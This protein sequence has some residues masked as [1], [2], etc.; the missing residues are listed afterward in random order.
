MSQ[1]TF[2]AMPEIVWALVTAAVYAASQVVLTADPSVIFT[3]TFWQT[4][5]AVAAIR[6]VAGAFL[7]VK[8]YPGPGPQPP[9][10]PPRQSYSTLIMPVQNQEPVKQGR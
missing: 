6:A 8:T 5:V 10:V 9:Q 1:Y 2:K 4:A 7:H 3:A